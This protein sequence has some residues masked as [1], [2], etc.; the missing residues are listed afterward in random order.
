MVFTCNKC[1]TTFTVKKNLTRHIKSKHEVTNLKC[2]KCEFTTT[3]KDKL[4]THIESKHYQNKVKCPEC[5]AEFSRQDNLERH[6]KEQHPQ[7]PLAL[8]P[9][10]NWAKEVERVEEEKERA[11]NNR[12]EEAP[13]EKS[14]F[15]K[16]LVEKKW[17]IRGEKDILKVFMDYREG[18]RTS[19]TRALRKSQLKI[20]IVIRVRMSRQ[21][22]EG[23]IDEVSQNFSGGQRLILRIEDFD[24]AYDESTQKIWGDFDNW[25]SNGSGWVLERVEALYLNTAVYNPFMERVIFLHHQGLQLERQSLMSRIRIMSASNGQCFQHCIQLKQMLFAW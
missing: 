20:N 9:N 8:T 10:F 18:V 14:A 5:P 13:K 12:E 15:K 4:K 25:L 16:Q 23:E 11:E 6:K 21:D 17:F 2:E 3:R 19:V 7:D 1:A 22:K 24:L